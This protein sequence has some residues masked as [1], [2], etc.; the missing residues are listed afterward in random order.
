MPYVIW[1]QWSPIIAPLP[2]FFS[3]DCSLLFS[4]LFWLWTLL[5]LWHLCYTAGPIWTGTNALLRNSEVLM[6]VMTSGLASNVCT[7]RY[8]DDDGNDGHNN[9]G[10]DFRVGEQ[11]MYLPV[12]LACS[13]LSSS[14]LQRSQGTVVSGFQL[15]ASSSQA[16]GCYT[17]LSKLFPHYKPTVQ[18]P[19]NWRLL[20]KQLG[21]HSGRR[22]G[23]DNLLLS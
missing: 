5:H 13:L 11:R 14:P 8:D 22:T 16:V 7:C 1:P 4:G 12:P 21:G 6:M 3:H 23:E 10:D 17:S 2:F 19:S 18:A 15:W 20:E 9:D